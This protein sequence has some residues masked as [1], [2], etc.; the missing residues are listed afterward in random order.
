MKLNK[1]HIYFTDGDFETIYTFGITNA[2]ILACA[3]RINKGL[4]TIAT[5]IENFDFGL[6]TYIKEQLDFTVSSQ[7]SI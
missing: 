1:Y 3:N 4:D 2:L 5:Y 7:E 6:C